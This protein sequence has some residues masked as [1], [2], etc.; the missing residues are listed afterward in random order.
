[1][2]NEVLLL[3]Q[4]TEEIQEQGIEATR[5][6]QWNEMSSRLE[7]NY[8]GITQVSQLFD[9]GGKDHCI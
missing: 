1:M 7:L 8:P 2:G 6:N 5:S 4:N 3:G 9:V